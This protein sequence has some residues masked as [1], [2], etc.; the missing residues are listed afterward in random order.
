MNLKNC[1]LGIFLDI[2]PYDNLADN[3]IA[4]FSN[5]GEHGILVNL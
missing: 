2:F 5:S 3:R 4:R 1:P